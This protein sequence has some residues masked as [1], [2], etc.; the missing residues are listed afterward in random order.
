MLGGVS[1]VTAVT[2]LGCQTDSI[3]PFGRTDNN[4]LEKLDAALLKKEGDA[5]LRGSCGGQQESAGKYASGPGFRF[6]GASD[7]VT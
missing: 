3:S 5:K 2:N 6:I 1:H 7:T 4:V